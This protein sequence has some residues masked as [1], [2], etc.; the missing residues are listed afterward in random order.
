MLLFSF[1]FILVL[2]LIGYCATVL[3]LVFHVP[4]FPVVFP[5]IF[6]LAILA[7]IYFTARVR[8]WLPAPE[9]DEPPAATWKERILRWSRDYLLY[10][11]LAP[12]IVLL[13]FLPA[14]QIG[15]HGLFHSGYVY[16]IILRGLPP[17][18]VTLPGTP[19]NDYWPYH[20]Y[21]ALLTQLFNAPPPFVSAISNIVLLGMS[22]LWVAALWK[23]LTRR[24][25]APAFYVL[26]PL[27]GS[28]L[29]YLLNVK[30]AGLLNLPAQLAPDLRLDIPI[31]RFVNFNGFSVGILLFLAALYFADRLLSADINRRDLSLL[32]FL[33]AAALLFHATTGIF[34]FAVLIPSLIV[35]RLLDRSRPIPSASDLTRSGRAIL[36][37]ILPAGLFLLSI[38][39]FIL[40]AASAMAVKTT[41]ELFSWTDVSSIFIMVYPVAIFFILEFLRAWKERDIP[42]LFLSIVT[43]WGFL[44]AIFI[45]LPDGNEYKFIHLSS[46]TLILVAALNF[47][48]RAQKYTVVR[49]GIP[50]PPES[51]GYHPAPRKSKLWR[52][53]L[54]AFLTL[55]LVY[56][57]GYGTWFFY[58]TYTHRH[59]AD[60]TYSGQ[61]ITLDTADFAPFAWIRD[62]TPADTVI[63]QPLN[64]KDWNYSY[65]SE[66]LPYIVAGHIYNE[67][68]PETAVRTDQ[69]K[70]LYDPGQPVEKRIEIVR[71]I[72][73]SLGARPV[74]VIYPVD[75]EFQSAIESEFG[76]TG[77]VVGDATIIFV[78]RNP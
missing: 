5:I 22:C 16:Q 13:L 44:L 58:T 35:A 34:I 33:G 76:F 17:E 39:I 30:L 54:L 25:A 12:I 78:L 32:T 14:L 27:L 77:Q 60:I 41:V 49:N 46:T 52:N 43:L 71:A 42:V 74:A 11:S 19:A 26:F 40:R 64:S 15:Y 45:K 24:N 36:G 38:G 66:R 57:T 56:N 47:S 72:L 37:W 31:I 50:Q 61:H 10:F 51:A 4:F 67:G 75:A 9:N 20:V 53:G 59:K 29:F 6:S 73:Q 48:G 1:L 55:A 3:A 69:V 23:S 2:G 63:V 21:F 7:A 18:N 70:R 68:I 8:T 62:N 28:N 65:F